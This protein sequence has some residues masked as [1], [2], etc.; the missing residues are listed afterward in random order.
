MEKNREIIIDKG[1]YA[2]WHIW[3]IAHQEADVVI[4]QTTKN[5]VM[6]SRE[7]IEK[8]IAENNRVYGVNTGFGELQNKLV[9]HGKLKKLQENLI[10][11]HCVG[12][13]EPFSPEEVRAAMMVRLI[14][15]SRGYSGVRL[16]LIEKLA[17]L[18]NKKVIPYV[19]SQGSVG[20][21]GDLSPLSHIALVLMG[22]GEVLQEGQ[23]SPAGK[24]LKKLDIKP[25]LLAEKE[26]LALNNGTSM[27]TAIACLNLKRAGDLLKIA[28]IAGALIVEAIN[29]F[30]DAFDEN[31]HLVRHHRGQQIV[32]SNFRKL[33]AGSELIDTRKAKDVQDSYSIRCMPQVHGAVRDAYKWCL[34]TVER[35]INATTDNPLVFP[36]HDRIISG[37]NFHGAP[38]AYSMDL[39]AI[40]LADL[41]SISE[42]RTTKILDHKNNNGLPPCL[43]SSQ[44][45]GLNSGLMIVQYTAA[46]LVAE[47]KVYAHPASVDSIPTSANQEDH[48]SFG[49]IAANK[50]R[51]VILNLQK[52]LSIELLCAFQALSFARKKMGKGTNTVYDILKTIVPEITE[53]RE[54]YLDMEKINALVRSNELT[55][56]LEE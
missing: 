23:R 18:I 53:D 42:R 25:I 46:A 38:I 29:G 41:G 20:C 35:E 50:C 26:G 27:M 30:S 13:G 55:D 33:L 28:D 37:G 45:V 8:C 16:E 51:E 11:S 5:R 9:P 40:I 34:E 21:S 12:V 24:V 32:A 17:E 7:V 47:N 52:I 3:E 10:R 36:E 54:F 14:S 22:D 19:P 1:K 56:L 15:L 4:S 49:S 2:V 44:E 6:R 39:L 43:I 48:V 31:V